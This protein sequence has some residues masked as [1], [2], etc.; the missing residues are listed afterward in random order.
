MAKLVARGVPEA[1]LISSIIKLRDDRSKYWSCRLTPDGRMKA[2]YKPHGTKT[3][4]FSSTKTLRGYG[5]NGQNRPPKM[6]AM[7][8]RDP[9]CLPGVIDLSQAENRLVAYLAEELRMMGC[10]ERGEDVHRLT[11]GLFFGKDPADISDEPGSCPL[12]GG[13]F[14]ERFWGKKGN[15]SCNY[16][17]GP[18]E[19][20]WNLEIP[21][22]DA[23][24][25]LNAY[26]KAYPNVR[27]VFQAD[28]KADLWK[29]RSLTNLRGRTVRV[30]GPLDDRMFKFGYAWRPS[31]TVADIVN[32]Q[33]L[34]P[35]YEDQET[36][37]GFHIMNQI[38]DSLEFQIRID[39]EGD[40]LYA[41][42]ALQ[43]LVASLEVPLV[44][45]G[46]TFTIPAELKVGGFCKGTVVD[47]KRPAEA[48]AGDLERIYATL[49]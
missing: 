7:L 26:H 4:R 25:L 20:A 10:F 18:E 46:R 24:W 33:G 40:F 16:D 31:S 19:L 6:K 27:G 45:K 8:L 5:S 43:K 34:I 2:N 9:G 28:V 21:V 29:S 23:K 39:G 44:A 48:V 49:G 17:I 47:V 38:H 42:T 37:H 3:G 36:Y 14:S 41:A 1:K 32:P 12:A 22:K 30:Y 11:A 15:H 35:L 13:Q